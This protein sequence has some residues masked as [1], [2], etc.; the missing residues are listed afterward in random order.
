[1]SISL[2]DLKVGNLYR[3]VPT[4][5]RPWS[6]PFFNVV[7]LN[8]SGHGRGDRPKAD[9]IIMYLGREYIGSL[10]AH[11]FLIDD[12]KFAVNSSYNDDFQHGLRVL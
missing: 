2:N 6:R 8:R 9:Q 10:D 5:Y 12:Q 11:I 7:D 4:D 3:W 1:M